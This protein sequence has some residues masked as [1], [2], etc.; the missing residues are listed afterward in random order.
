MDGLNHFGRIPCRDNTRGDIPG[1]HASGANDASLSNRYAFQ[2]QTI[3]P[4]KHI[5]FDQRAP[6]VRPVG[7]GPVRSG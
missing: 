4:D 1:Y 6:F 5:I 3:C 2:D 7:S